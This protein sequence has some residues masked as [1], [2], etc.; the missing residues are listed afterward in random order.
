MGNFYITNLDISK[1]GK[2]FQVWKSKEMEPQILSL[3][4]LQHKL[5]IRYNI[6]NIILK[7]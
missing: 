6:Q 5:S 4:T 1:D 2:K 7:L 3:Y